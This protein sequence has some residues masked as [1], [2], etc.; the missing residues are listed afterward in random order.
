[1]SFVENENVLHNRQ[2]DADHVYWTAD[3]E[4]KQLIDQKSYFIG[5]SFQFY[6]N[7]NY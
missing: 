3:F 6:R 4:L 7:D 5:F 1:M 2:I